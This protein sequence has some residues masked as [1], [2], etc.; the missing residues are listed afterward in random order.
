MPEKKKQDQNTPKKRLFPPKLFVH[1][2]LTIFF[3][4]NVICADKGVT[5]LYGIYNNNSKKKY[6][7]KA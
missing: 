3:F 6:T 2:F 5:V 4:K 1:E 7:H